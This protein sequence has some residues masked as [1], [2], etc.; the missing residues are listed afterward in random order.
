MTSNTRLTKPKY[1]NVKYLNERTCCILTQFL[2]ENV[3]EVRVKY[4]TIRMRVR[5]FCIKTKESRY[6][7]HMIYTAD[8]WPALIVRHH[9]WFYN[10]AVTLICSL[11][12][13]MQIF[14]FRAR[15]LKSLDMYSQKKKS[16]KVSMV[17]K[18]KRWSVNGDIFYF[19]KVSRF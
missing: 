15:L 5:N 2:C 16:V 14:I 1:L 9:R 7:Q 10:F 17:P 19:L 11:V 4:P 3:H 6:F 13:N 8:V 18:L 12:S